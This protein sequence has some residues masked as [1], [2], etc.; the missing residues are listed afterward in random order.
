MVPTVR[1]SQGKSK[2]HGA[3]VNKNAEKK[4]ELLYAD[5]IQ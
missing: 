3:K 1:E 4:L 2:Y 5:C